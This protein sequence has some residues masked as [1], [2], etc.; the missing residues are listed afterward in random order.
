M[1][2]DPAS[3]G[4]ARS[5]PRLGDRSLFPDLEARAYLSYAA[6]APASL[7]VIQAV[8]AALADYARLGQGAFPLW[9]MR[10][11]RLRQKLGE[12]LGVSSNDLG[13]SSGTTRAITDLALAIPWREGDSLVLFEPEFPANVT[14]WRLAAERFGLVTHFHPLAGAEHDV[15]RVLGPLEARLKSGVRLVAVSAVQFKTGLRMPLADMS[16]LCHRYGAEIFVDAIQALGVVPFDASGLDLDYVAGGAHKWLM[17]IEGAGYLYVREACGKTLRPLTAGWSSHE[18]AFAFLLDGPGH[19]DYSRPLKTGAQVFEGGSN[20]VVSLA[21][22]EAALDTLLELGVGAIFGHVGA[23]LDALQSG[24][25]HLGIRHLRAA[26]PA[27]R[28]GILSLEV[29]AGLSVRLVAERLRERGIFASTPDG[30]LRFAPH[31]PNAPSEVPEVLS[32]LVDV[33]LGNGA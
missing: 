28:S 33:G 21:G 17:G 6:V 14:P 4:Q 15:D 5:G 2:P 27:A 22:L 3:A 12:L 16:R 8:S 18:Q 23:Y 25:E 19:L 13:L 32:A 9:A 24:L 1:A 26:E 30:L 31:F 29:P 10:R 20:S 11:E 7:P